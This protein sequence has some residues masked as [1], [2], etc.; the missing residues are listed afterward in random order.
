MHGQRNIKLFKVVFDFI[1]LVYKSIWETTWMNHL[2]VSIAQNSTHM[3]RRS[4]EVSC[5]CGAP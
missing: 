5:R 2:K 4:S 1:L 3:F